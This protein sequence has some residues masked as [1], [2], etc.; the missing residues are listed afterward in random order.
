MPENKMPASNK[1]KALKTLLPF[2][3]PYKRQLLL[4]T[5]SLILAA[6]ATLV[7]PLCFR[8][9]IDQGFS[10]A[11]QAQ[12]NRTFIN[13]FGAAVVLAFASS[14]RYYLVSWLG[15]RITCDIRK[16]VYSH[17]IS[18]SP[19]FFET[20]QSGEI[21]S[22]INNDTTIIQIL[23]GTSIS[24]AVRNL[25][26][27]L[28]GMA[29]MFITSIQLSLL[30]LFTL[31]ITV[32]PVVFMG[33][34]VR[35]LSRNSQDKIALTSAIAGEKINAIFTVQSFA[36]EEKEIKVFNQSIEKSFSASINRSAARGKLTFV[37]ILL[38]FTSI[39][40]VLWLGAYAVSNQE[41][42]GGQL[43]QFFL[44]AVI[45]A[46]AIAALSEV[47]G[48]AQRAMGAGERLLELL[49][50]QPKVVSPL[51]PHIRTQ[52]AD[53]A[54]HVQIEN[55]SFAYSSNPNLVLSD[56]N[57]SIQ[58]G[59]KI[60][61]VGPSGSGKTTLFKLIQRFYDPQ[62]G[63]IKF[64]DVDIREFKL[65][66]LRRLI[67]LV[68]QDISIF[69]ENALENIRYGREDATDAEVHE[70]AVQAAV[71]E[72][73]SRL[74][75][76]YESFLGDRGVRL[77]G[78]QKQRIAIARALLKN[79]PLLLLDEAT[80]SLDAESERLV[81]QALEVAMNGRTTIVIAHRLSTVKKADRIIVMEHGRIIET[82][83]HA[84][85]L[86]QSGLYSQ[87]AK[88]QFTDI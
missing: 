11:S 36:N 29:M 32:I 76:R 60:A 63:C 57:L 33:K 6:G 13:L 84:S 22:R 44:Y 87:L 21:L 2:I 42:S 41:I 62:F 67:G 40:L 48:D 77:S 43:T 19:E 24:M 16:K 15:E 65:D 82:G 83:N 10:E 66:D 86:A 78:G 7:I 31:L 75:E 45:V 1:L 9:I 81:Q 59:E 74:P 46:G 34:K 26:L 71:D 38:G 23:L 56:I 50:S 12:I 73:I 35:Q 27:L 68:P 85:L 25:F 3:R 64:N 8:T 88:L 69:S 47:L 80:S 18:Q 55:L 54:I 49:N 20:Q 72:F 39:I 51:S 58:A 79:P 37:A 30:I 61:L 70:A 28:G 14:L 17:I 5:I 52:S 4:A 53:K